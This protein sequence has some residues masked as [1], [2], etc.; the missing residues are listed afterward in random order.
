MAGYTIPCLDCILRKLDG[1]WLTAAIT[2]PNSS[3]SPW[4]LHSGQAE[5]RRKCKC[6]LELA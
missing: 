5:G 4:L 1:T 2:F 6:G 3:P